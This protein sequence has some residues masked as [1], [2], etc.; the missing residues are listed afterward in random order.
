[1][2]WKGRFL[3]HSL[4]MVKDEKQ[5]VMKIAVYARDITRRRQMEADLQRR[6]EI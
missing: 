6:G 4:Y 2:E 1:M 3:D 5:R